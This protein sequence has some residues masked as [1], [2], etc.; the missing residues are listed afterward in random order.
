MYYP[1]GYAKPY[2]KIEHFLGVLGKPHGI[3]S[4][5]GKQVLR[6]SQENRQ[7]KGKYRFLVVYEILLFLGIT[8]DTNTYFL[9]S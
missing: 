3:N 2:R 7:P 6:A 8:I 5:P 4:I 9:F 1:D